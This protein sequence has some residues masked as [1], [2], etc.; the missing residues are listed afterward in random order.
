MPVVDVVNLDG[1]KVG[2]VELADA[3]FGAEVNEHLLHEASRWYLSGS[4]PR[5]G[6][7]QGQERSQRRRPQALAAEGHG[8]R[9]RW[10]DSFAS[11]APW[12]HGSRTE[13]AL[14]R[15]RVAEEDAARRAA[16]G[17]VRE[18]RGAEADHH[19]CVVARHAQDQDAC[20]SRWTS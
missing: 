14:V 12:R 2:Q 16:L 20:A 15:I 19:R 5:H 1:K 3:V 17:A 8:P 13:A 10:L 11:V 18:A 6:Q 4:A 9:A 7:D